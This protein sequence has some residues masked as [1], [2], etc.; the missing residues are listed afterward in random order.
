MATR[1][2][3]KTA[4]RKRPSDKPKAAKPSDLA[5]EAS[6]RVRPQVRAMRAAKTKAPSKTARRPTSTTAKRAKTD[7]PA[8]LGTGAEV[9]AATIIYV[10]G[11]GNKPVASVLKCQWDRALMGFDLGERS[12]LAYWVNREYYPEPSAEECRDGDLSPKA[13]R[14]ASGDHVIKRLAEEPPEQIVAEIAES[15]RAAKLLLA[16]TEHIET[17][18]A[19]LQVSDQVTIDAQRRKGLSVDAKLLPLP[20]PLRRWITR[21]VTKAFLKDVNDLFYV[22][23][24]R[25][26]MRESVLERLRVGG[27]PFVVIGH[28]QGSMIAYDVLSSLKAEDYDI[29]LFVTIGS[30]LGVTEVQDE[31]KRL[32]KQKKLAVPDCVRKWV[33]LSDRLDPVAADQRFSSDYAA[34]AR[35]VKLVDDPV[36]NPESPR[37]PHSGSGYLRTEKVRFPVYEAVDMAAFQPVASFVIAR[38]VSR[39]MEA[40]GRAAR[41]ELLIE[42]AELKDAPKGNASLDD[43]RRNVVQKIRECAPGVPDDE[44]AV[45]PMQRF[46]SASLTREEAE[47]VAGSLCSPTLGRSIRRIWLNAQKVALL[48]KSIQT[49]QAAPA[50]AAYSAKGAGVTWAVLDSGVNGKHP[51]FASGGIKAQ[52]D[53]TKAGAVQDKGADANTDENGH[54][55]HVCGIITGQDTR[56]NKKGEDVVL[57]GVAPA[58]KVVS[59]RVLDRDGSGK[60]SWIIKALDHI[61][62]TNEAAGQLVIHGVNLSLGGPFDQSSYG[63][64]HTPLCQELRRLWNQGVVV[65]LAAGNEGFARL[66]SDGGELDANMDLSIGDPANLDEAI[67]VGSV[68]K[69][70]PHTYGISYFS[71]RGPTADGRQKPDVVAPGERILSCRHKPLGAGKGM[72]E[73]YLEMSGTSMAAPHVSGMLAA[74]LGARREFIGYPNKVKQIL[75]DNCTDLKRDRNHQGAGL[76]NL[77]RMLV[78]T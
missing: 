44:L 7:S 77:V 33:N 30:P 9:E 31:I 50:H 11:I 71:S 25:E 49:V 14:D 28:S 16:L 59:Y 75:L 10:H 72:E 23:A 68:H 20:G 52:F 19:A 60:D 41:H 12:R 42:L 15:P 55:T 64:G 45:D 47:R 27:G 62:A 65:V 39:A 76:P 2:T 32:T 1:K 22:P 46:V 18:S 29:R 38:D 57:T 24:R 6:A 13:S 8:S 26:V 78:A 70:K 69:E 74:F 43:L 5:P 34:N 17:H 4:P 36:E 56:K 37:H 40:S 58:A 3:K 73:L 61:A 66:V 53:C 54:G 35:G 67:C 21:Q 48:D 63:C 51:H